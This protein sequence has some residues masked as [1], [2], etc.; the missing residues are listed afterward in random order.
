MKQKIIGLAGVARSGKDTVCKLLCDELHKDGLVGTRY[1]LADELKYDI[2]PFLKEKCGIDI[3]NCTDEEKEMVRPFLLWYGTDFMRVK[4]K[5]RAWIDRLHDRIKQDTTSDF[6][7][8][9]DI[10]YA[11]EKDG[12][13]AVWVQEELG[14]NIIYVSQY[15][16]TESESVY[17]FEDL[18]TQ[19]TVKSYMQPP[20]KYEKRHDPYLREMA[21]L[22]FE[23][24]RKIVNG[25]SDM[26]YLKSKVQE[27][28][29][30]IK[31]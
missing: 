4:T 22:H 7:F 29:N 28:Y 2:N 12:N 16:I 31:L 18:H 25:K 30:Q 9:T 5:G 14:G 20:N 27:L 8:I 21:D 17:G 23:W 13:E 15:T 24:E 19:S 11:A 6:I 10:R 3:L 26:K 1:A